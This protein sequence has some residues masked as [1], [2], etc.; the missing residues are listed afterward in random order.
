MM[1]YPWKDGSL[2]KVV[3]LHVDLLLILDPLKLIKM[4]HGDH[5]VVS[6]ESSEV[7]Q[8]YVYTVF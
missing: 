1:C 7:V 4:Y 3:D 5:E 8:Y 6:D 2:E